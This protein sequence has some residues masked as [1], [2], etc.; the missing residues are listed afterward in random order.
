MRLRIEVGGFGYVLASSIICFHSS[1]QYKAWGFRWLTNFSTGSPWVEFRWD[2]WVL[3]RFFTSALQMVI[4]LKFR[5]RATKLYAE[6]K[7]WLRQKRQV[8]E[9]LSME[10]SSKLVTIYLDIAPKLAVL[11][12]CFKMILTAIIRWKLCK[13]TPQATDW[14]PFVAFKATLFLL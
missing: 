10:K 5:E 14:V 6:H 13:D 8:F 7:R 1:M 2:W 3:I 12:N 4:S 9:T 11:T